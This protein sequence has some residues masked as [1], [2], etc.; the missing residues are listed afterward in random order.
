MTLPNF[1]VREDIIDG[2]GPWHWP[3]EDSGAWDGPV[4]DWVTSHRAIIEALPNRRGCVQ[5]GGNCGLY[6]ALLSK[7]FER[8]YTL[9]PDSDN[10]KFL[11]HNVEAHSGD[12][13]FYREG[14]VGDSS[15]KVGLRRLTPHNVGM[16]QVVDVPDGD[17]EMHAIDDLL[18]LEDGPIDL[19]WL[20]IEG[21]EYLALLGA[22][23]TIKTWL[24]VIG[25]ERASQSI[26][27][28]LRPLGYR[29]YA[30]SKM[31]T[32]FKIGDLT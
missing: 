7:M 1:R 16:H 20:D 8:V 15:K 4:D 14:A 10:F 26:R 21:G 30:E 6:P 2:L 24:P 12:N 19:I 3:I 31:D 32:F 29:E 25:V 11:T 22:M 23:E 5:A 17:I 9:E 18:S 27:D 13:V 28:L